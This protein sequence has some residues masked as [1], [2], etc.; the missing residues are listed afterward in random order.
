LRGILPLPDFTAE[1]DAMHALLLIRAD[2]LM[3]APE[4][5]DG[6]TGLQLTTDAVEGYEIKRWPRHHRAGWISPE[7]PFDEAEL[8]YLA[9]G[10]LNTD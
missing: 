4:A 5:S 9:T 3:S 6:A 2:A 7:E 10:Q 8:A 1:A